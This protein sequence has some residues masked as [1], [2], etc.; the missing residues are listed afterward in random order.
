LALRSGALTVR[1]SWRKIVLD[2]QLPDLRVQ[3]LNITLG[4]RHGLLADLRV[5]RPGSVLLQLLLPGIDLVRMHLIALRQVGHSRLLPQCL[6]RN[7]RLQRRVNRSSRLPHRRS[8]YHDR[9][10][11]ASN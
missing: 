4:L 2:R 7:L 8:V 11:S 3:P 10:A 9:T 1:T 6:K 5:E